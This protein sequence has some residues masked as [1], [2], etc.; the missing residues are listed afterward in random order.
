MMTTATLLIFVLALLCA[1][2]AVPLKNETKTSRAHSKHEAR[3]NHKSE[4]GTLN[5][6]SS[7]R[8]RHSHR[9]D[10]KDKNSTKLDELKDKHSMKSNGNTDKPHSPKHPKVKSATKALEKGNKRDNLNHRSKQKDMRKHSSSNETSDS[11]IKPSDKK[12]DKDNLDA[13]AAHV[14]NGQPVSGHEEYPFIVDLSASDVDIASKRFCTGSHVD[15]SIILTAAH[16]VLNDGYRSAVYATIGR[17]ELEDDHE[18]NFHSR[19][20]RTIASMV[21]PNYTGI[22]SPYDVALLLLNESSNAP[23]I[24]LSTESPPV[25]AEVWVVGYG[26]Q[27]IGTLEETGQPVEILS[28]RLQK[29]NLKIESRSFCDIPDANLFTEEG[30]LCTTGVQIGSSACRGDSGGP[31]TLKTDKTATQVGIT[32][33]GDSQC[34][35]EQAGVFTD[36]ASVHGWIEEAKPRL[37]SLLNTANVTLEDDLKDAEHSSQ[38]GLH[39][40]NSPEE[41]E[42]SLKYSK[43]AHKEGVKFYK[44]KTNFTSPHRVRVSLCDGPSG[45][46]ARLMVRNETDNSVIHDNGSCDDGKL[47]QVSFHTTKDALVVGV[48]GNH[49]V[50]YKLSFSSTKAK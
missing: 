35:A 21:H 4:I 40:A 39:P 2:N 30:L 23:V 33:Y 16:C 46:S 26:I 29:T 45:H 6:P 34:A 25:G 47:S 48:T 42:E 37:L 9:K 49:S 31:L 27:R 14:I 8:K 19:T 15:K 44:L 20:Y 5:T 3:S 12:I 36:V 24:S 50:P 7:S 13:R 22:G 41:A 32:S 17:V 11:S 38:I 43:T 28:G 1:A 10:S 18:D